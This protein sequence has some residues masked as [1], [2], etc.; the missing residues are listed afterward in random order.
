MYF[1]GFGN[2]LELVPLAEKVDKLNAVCMQCFKDASFS[3]RICEGL[4]VSDLT[5]IFISK[6]FI[7]KLPLDMKRISLVQISCLIV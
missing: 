3:K 6:Y 2:I 5:I 1:L 4:E 7:R